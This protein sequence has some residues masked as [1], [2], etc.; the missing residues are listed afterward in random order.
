VNH[1]SN[2]SYVVNQ[3]HKEKR[4]YKADKWPIVIASYTI[5]SPFTVVVE[6]SNTAL[7]G[8]TVFGLFAYM[9]FADTTDQRVITKIKFV[10]ST[11]SFEFSFFVHHGVGRVYFLNKVH[12]DSCA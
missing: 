11:H 5:I 4:D 1:H 12:A 2:I 7:A 9:S 6:I 10:K 8:T 3:A